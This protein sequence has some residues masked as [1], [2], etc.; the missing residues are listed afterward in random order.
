[1][2]KDSLAL[3]RSKRDFSQTAEPA[4]KTAV[5]E[6]KALRF[7]VQ[8]HDAT[9]LHYDF[10]LELDGVF[11]SWAVTKGPSLNP[12]IKRLAV[13]V[14]DHPSP[15]PPLMLCHGGGATFRSSGGGGCSARNDC[16]DEMPPT[17]TTTR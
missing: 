17:P 1:M 6:G 9:R 13:E 12:A 4:G 10:R 11:K 16:D 8:R 5:S 7:V 15:P 3:Y 14:E 2:P